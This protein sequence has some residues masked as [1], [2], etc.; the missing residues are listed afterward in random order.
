MLNS[1]KGF[2]GVTTL[3]QIGTDSIFIVAEDERSLE[4]TVNTILAGEAE[5]ISDRTKACILINQDLFPK[6]Q[7]QS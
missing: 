2:Y 3:V 7:S 4:R 1:F 5:Y 6:S